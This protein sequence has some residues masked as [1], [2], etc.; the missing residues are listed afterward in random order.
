ME[1]DKQNDGKPVARKTK[2]IIRRGPYIESVCY[3][4]MCI[5]LGCIA[6]LFLPLLLLFSVVMFILGL[7][8]FLSRNST[9]YVLKMFDGYYGGKDP[10]TGFIQ[11]V[12][13]NKAIIFTAQSAVLM[14]SDLGAKIEEA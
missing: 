11:I 9:V 4:V 12:S 1:L 14:A 8:G 5:F 2:I 10:K 3:G 13:R 7:A 6:C